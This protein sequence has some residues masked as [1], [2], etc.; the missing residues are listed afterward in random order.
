MTYDDSVQDRGDEPCAAARAI[1]HVARWESVGSRDDQNRRCFRPSP[2]AGRAE[3][4]V[5]VAT[6]RE[7]FRLAKP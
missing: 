6:E 3:A 4:G 5:G 1:Q 7:I 2:N